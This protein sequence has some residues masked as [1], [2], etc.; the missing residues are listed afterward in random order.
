MRIQDSHSFIQLL[1][2]CAMV[3]FSHLFSQFFPSFLTRT[4]LHFRDPPP[5]ELDH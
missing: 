1:K 4:S 2:G 3:I 5:S